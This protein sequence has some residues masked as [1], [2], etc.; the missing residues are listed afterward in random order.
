MQIA[1]NRDLS[2]IEGEFE[3]FFD[4]T[5]T[6]FRHND[7]PNLVFDTNRVKIKWDKEKISLIIL[8]QMSACEVKKFSVKV[9]NV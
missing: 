1:L 2:Q 9:K 5:N 8:D 4:G 3:L 7:S 6:I